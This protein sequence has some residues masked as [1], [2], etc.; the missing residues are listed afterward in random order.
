M[1]TCLY[2]DNGVAHETAILLGLIEIANRLRVT[3][4]LSYLLQYTNRQIVT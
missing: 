2:S 4:V 3:T 1:T